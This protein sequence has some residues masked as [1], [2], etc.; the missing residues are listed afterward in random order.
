MSEYFLQ[1]ENL[2]LID[3]YVEDVK[4]IELDQIKENESLKNLTMDNILLIKDDF[5]NKLFY[6]ENNNIFI[7]GD[8][9]EKVQKLYP[10][11]L[12]E[13]KTFGFSGLYYNH[14]LLI[15]AF[16]KNNH[17]IIYDYQVKDQEF[18]LK[19]KILL[20]NLTGGFYSKV[21]NKSL[22]IAQNK[23]DHLIFYKFNIYQND[24]EPD[25]SIKFDLN[26][27]NII[28][29]ISDD[30]F[31]VFD[32]ILF[33]IDNKT[34][35][36]IEKL[37]IKPIFMES[38]K[39]PNNYLTFVS[40]NENVIVF[41]D[42]VN[43]RQI[44]KEEKISEIQL[45]DSYAI[46]FNSTESKISIYALDNNGLY[47]KFAS[48]NNFD[49]INNVL[50]SNQNII[51]DIDRH[52]KLVKLPKRLFD[53]KNFLGYGF[54]SNNSTGK[55]AIYINNGKLSTF[56]KN[57]SLIIGYSKN[58]S[59]LFFKKEKFQ[60]NYEF[61]HN[62]DLYELKKDFIL[63]TED[64]EK[65]DNILDIEKP[66]FMFVENPNIEIFFKSDK[67][68]SME[69]ANHNKIINW[70]KDGVVKIELISNSH[71]IEIKTKSNITILGYRII[72]KE[73]VINNS[74]M[75]IKSNENDVLVNDKILD[76]YQ[77]FFPYMNNSEINALTTSPINK[78]KV[79]FNLLPIKINL[80]NYSF[81]RHIEINNLNQQFSRRYL[82][83]NN[84]KSILIY[85][86]LSN[87]TI[88]E[89]K[90]S[91]ID[92][93]KKILYVNP[94][95]II[96]SKLSNEIDTHI[97]LINSE[98]NMII[99]YVIS[100][101]KEENLTE[102][103][104]F[105]NN[106]LVFATENQKYNTI[107]IVSFDSTNEV[108]NINKITLEEK[109]RKL[110]L[111]NNYLLV[112]SSS[113]ELIIYDINISQTLV[114]LVDENLVDFDII[115]NNLVFLTHEEKLKIYIYEIKPNF[116][117][118]HEEEV[119]NQDVNSNIVFG[120]GRVLLYNHSKILIYNFD[121]FNGL[122]KV[123]SISEEFIHYYKNILVTKEEIKYKVYKFTPEVKYIENQVNCNVK[124][125][126]IMIKN[127]TDETE[128]VTMFFQ[129]SE[130]SQL[131]LNGIKINER[132]GNETCI[133]K[134]NIRLKPT[135]E[136]II[137]SDDK[138]SS[139]CGLIVGKFL[140]K[141][142]CF[143]EGTMIKTTEGYQPI[144]NL[145]ENDYIINEFNEE[146]KIKIIKSWTTTNFS[147][148]TIPFVI[149]KNSLK[150]DYPSLDTYISPFHKIKLPNGNFKRAN[151]IN[152]PFIK[153]LRNNTNFLSN[154]DFKIEKITYYN[155][156]L[157][158]ESNF[159][160]NDMI[161]ESLDESNKLIAY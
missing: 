2:K 61:T 6:K 125:E 154:G 79:E 68:S 104:T 27:E 35:K 95:I 129:T 87:T 54:Y 152:L 120:P 97:H 22:I 78:L 66:N 113:S 25:D 12:D 5:K 132:I 130:K 147:K 7:I 72:K 135:Q 11:E 133:A 69:V 71:I 121:K 145:K 39:V 28:L 42:K 34:N 84:D 59:D 103:F 127:E 83:E 123:N 102:L 141:L 24:F 138:N 38:F 101:N 128:D 81:E 62:V 161:V 63:I 96:L 36:L 149:P 64:F 46:L 160:A 80:P 148:G 52:L 60:I 73:D 140:E 105:H 136:A 48:L 89:Y 76:S 77:T 40:T 3:E 92:G 118:V 4:V 94:I 37:D 134:L 18:E 14:Q 67:G 31:F 107:Y 29:S 19:D 115:F 65:T 82:I 99:P 23:T 146:I 111:F 153:Q 55:N 17:V 110:K 13:I 70:N 90:L 21:I 51:L 20:N 155:F 16:L 108:S 44:I 150:L 139:F 159:I 10:S 85:D 137:K 15:F 30:Y 86:L 9:Y 26:S 116:E 91:N 93:I 8:N 144:E 33:V 112:E 117:L 57:D 106:N 109:I 156:V 151:E 56:K 88:K 43:I 74:I 45:E 75:V 100:N 119:E 158:K 1:I 142:P 53:E 49:N 47:Q 58:L 32:E 50:L 126:S 114:S 131:K 41:D 98:N 143:L 124:L 157:E 122:V